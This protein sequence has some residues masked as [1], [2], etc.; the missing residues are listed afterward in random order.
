[1]IELMMT[2]E[3]AEQPKPRDVSWLAERLNYIWDTYFPDIS[4]P[5]PV[6][7]AFGR[8]SKTR[9]GSIGM[10]GWRRHGAFQGYRTSE[11]VDD[12]TTVIKLTGY[13]KHP[14]IPEYVLDVTLAHEIV[15][16]AHGFHSPHPQLYKHPHQGNIV[17]DEL[18]KRGLGD[19]LKKQKAWLKAHWEGV[20][21]K[22]STKPRRQ[23]VKRVSILQLINGR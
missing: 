19:L 5:N 16:Y 17:N 3:L 15:H 9:L 22:S 18:K 10:Q 21:S 4:R 8:A 2:E 20:A 23:R 11:K 14:D 13:F 12:G 6:V 7:A 1:M